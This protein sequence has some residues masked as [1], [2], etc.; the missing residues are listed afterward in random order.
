MP[1]LPVTD[2]DLEQNILTN[3]GDIFRLLHDA[4]KVNTRAKTVYYKCAFFLLAANIEALLYHYI[5]CK[6][7][8]DENL[9]SKANSTKLKHLQYVSPEAVGSTK[10]LAIAE[11]IDVTATLGSI[12]RD[13]NTMNKFCKDHI[14]IGATLFDELEYVR[15]KRNEI[16]IQGLRSTSRSYTKRQVNKAGE[17]MIRMLN[18]LEAMNHIN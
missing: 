2:S 15:T 3:F 6:C 17:T 7:R 12:T 4:A 10:K 16:H 5:E 13:F 14:G 11:E 8:L 9:I 1:I 18:E